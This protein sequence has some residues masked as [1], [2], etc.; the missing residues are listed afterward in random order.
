M[1]QNPG[2]II[3]N[4]V[5]MA[6]WATMLSLFAACTALPPID[7]NSPIVNEARIAEEPST[8]SEPTPEPLPTI[9]STNTPVPSVSSAT[10]T[11]NLRTG[12][13]TVYDAVDILLPGE[14][15]QIIGRNSASTWWQVI[16]E[17]GLLWISAAVTVPSNVTTDI[18][19][20]LAPPTPT[21][22]PVTPT[23]T[24]PPLPPTATPLPQLQ[25]SIRNVFGQTNQ[26]ITH[27]RG[28]IRDR[29]GN[30]INGVRV[31]VRSGSFCTVSNPSGAPGG[32]PNGNYDILLD[33]FAK[34]GLWSVAIVNGPAD[35]TD[36]KCNDGLVALSEEVSV[37]TN[38]L[39]GVAYVEWWKNY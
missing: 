10:T 2:V 28:D 17:N 23:H 6:I 30:P 1:R 33:N 24:P 12:P 21:V 29:S 22:A 9:T 25:Y 31:R 8:P 16:T 39:E 7:I 36:T 34:D 37:P 35:P 18:P 27:I 38:T 26:A 13:S 5:K 4:T 11:V 19:V 20:V 15:V 14:S 32:Y 3:Q